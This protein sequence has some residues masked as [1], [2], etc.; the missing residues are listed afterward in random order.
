[1]WSLGVVIFT[2]VNCRVPFNE[3]H[4]SVIYKMQMSQRYRFNERVDSDELK[5]L[6]KALLQP[7]PTLRPTVDIV[8]ADQWFETDASVEGNLL[9]DDKCLSS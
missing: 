5:R 9:F 1:M 7:N 6:V 8:L 3:T 2:M 4:P